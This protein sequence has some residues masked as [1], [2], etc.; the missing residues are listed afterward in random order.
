VPRPGECN[1]LNYLHISGVLSL[2]ISVHAASGNGYIYLTWLVVTATCFTRG[3]KDISIACCQM[4]A[5][6]SFSVSR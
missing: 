1:L 6:V 2:H 5:L 3:T 4:A